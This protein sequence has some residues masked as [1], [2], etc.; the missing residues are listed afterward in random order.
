MG[1][2]RPGFPDLAAKR[3]FLLSVHRVY[4][5]Q[6]QLPARSLLHRRVPNLRTGTFSIGYFKT[7]YCPLLNGCLWAFAAMLRTSLQKV[8][9]HI[10]TKGTNSTASGTWRLKLV[11]LQATQL[12]VA[13]W[14][15]LLTSF[16]YD[17]KSHKCP[18]S[19]LFSRMLMMPFLAP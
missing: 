13:N 11:D 8:K 12:E 3:R 19:L 1:Q 10:K 15:E 4:G 2:E 6:E 14:T 17:H 9:W 16:S 7:W 18:P 5:S